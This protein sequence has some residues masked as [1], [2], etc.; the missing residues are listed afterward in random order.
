MSIKV[1]IRARR[2]DSEQSQSGRPLIFSD[3]EGILSTNFFGKGEVK[4]L[5]F[6]ERHGISTCGVYSIIALRAGTSTGKYLTCYANGQVRADGHF[7]KQE[8]GSSALFDVV[9]SATDGY[10]SLRNCMYHN[11]LSSGLSN[12]TADAKVPFTWEQ[13]AFVKD[14]LDLTHIDDVV[15]GSVGSVSVIHR[16]GF[17]YPIISSTKVDIPDPSNSV[18]TTITTSS[19]QECGKVVNVIK[20][21]ERKEESEMEIMVALSDDDDYVLV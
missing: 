1:F 2:G 17:P 11:Y 19:S 9:R 3:F 6:L 18:A 4:H 7:G 12:V 10:I 14:S 15:V 5:W 21:E 13:L 16:G 8:L 20:R